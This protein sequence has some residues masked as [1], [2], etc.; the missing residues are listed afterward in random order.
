MPLFYGVSEIFLRSRKPPYETSSVKVYLAHFSP[1]QVR[2]LGDVLAHL[3]EAWVLALP[4]PDLL[5]ESA[6]PF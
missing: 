5:C 4:V 6:V 3:Q 2:P 1:P